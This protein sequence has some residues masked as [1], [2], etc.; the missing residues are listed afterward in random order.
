MP[1]IKAIPRPLLAGIAC[2]LLS[3][4][5]GC[6]LGD[7]QAPGCQSD[8]EC[9]PDW[10]CRAGACFHSNTKMS[11]PDDPGDAGPDAQSPAPPKG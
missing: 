2:I 4:A 1:S 8:D 3:L 9:G 11:A 5:V 10:I 7:E 6:A